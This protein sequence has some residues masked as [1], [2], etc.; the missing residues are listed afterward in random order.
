[1]R[2]KGVAVAVLLVVVAGLAF[3]LWPGGGGGS[4]DAVDDA[5][6]VRPVERGGA[7][8][9]YTSRSRSVDGRTLAV[10]VVVTGDPVAVKRLLIGRT[11]A[12]WEGATNDT[13]AVV[14]TDGVHWRQ[15]RGAAR[16][17]FV[18]PPDGDGRWVPADYQ[19]AS[20]DYLGTRL[21]VRA[22]PAPSDDWTAL[23]A[24]QEYWDWFRLRHTVTGVAP[25]GRFVA[26]DFRHH[27]SV[28]E[29]RRLDHGHRG[30]GS[31]GWLSVVEV[32]LTALL[33]GGIAGSAPSAAPRIRRTLRRGASGLPLAAGLGALFLG[34]R[35]T[36]IALETSFPR[37]DPRL[38]AAVLYPALAA[39]L[40]ALVWRLAP[41]R[42]PWAAFALAGVGL[43]AGIGVDFWTLGVTV[44][45]TRLLLHRAGLLVAIGVL[46]AGC[47]ATGPAGRRMRWL[48]GVAWIGALLL[49]LADLV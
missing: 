33:L 1:M 46:A 5:E 10:N 16:Y 23:Q 48:G 19:L 21:H 22:Y 4:L 3:G 8:W 9:P 26:E 42:R 24:H 32:A 11:P 44:L 27:P 43:G 7:I 39:G 37:I 35:A 20:G 40:P 30:G 38:F 28:S 13:R 45:P 17:T 18:R 12:E 34:V 36:G 41:G 31:A 49:P 15:A 29:V 2:S 47:A 14:D 25:A 6:L